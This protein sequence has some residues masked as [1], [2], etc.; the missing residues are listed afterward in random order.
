MLINNEIIKSGFSRSILFLL[1]VTIE[2]FII[3]INYIH[4]DMLIIL[5]STT[6]PGTTDEILV[7]FIEKL[8]YK[9]GLT[10]FIGYSPE[11]EDPGNKKYNTKNIP[12]IVS[13]YT[14]NCLKMTKILLRKVRTIL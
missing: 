4:E 11:R 5:E 9:I 12:K 6:Y 13:G 8:N 14:K 2:G 1:G 10:F 7:P 3:R